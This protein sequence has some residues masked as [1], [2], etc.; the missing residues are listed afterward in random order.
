MRDEPNDLTALSFMG[1][2][3]LASGD[4][5]KAFS[6]FEKA[7]K[8]A[9]N[10]YQVHAD[11]AY[12]A[13]R[14]KRREKAAQHF[15]IA[16]KLN[17]DFYQAWVN[18]SKLYFEMERFTDARN[19]LD[20]S[21]ACDPMEAD[22][23]DIHRAMQEKAHGK[24]EKIARSMLD[25]VPG[26][27]RAAYVLAHLAGTVGAY[28]QATKILKNT[29]DL[30]PANYWTRQSLI[31]YLEKIGAYIPA[32]IEA[33]ILTKL[34]P[35]SHSWLIL[36][37]TYEQTGQY[38]DAL[39][40]LD[41]AA[42]LIAETPELQAT[43]D[44]TRGHLLKIHGRYGE[45]EQA[46]RACIANSP[47]NGAG[48]WGLAD[49]ENF[50]FSEDDQ[51]SML[52]LADDY[53][54]DQDQRCLAAFALAKAYEQDHDY[55]MAFH[56]FQKA[57]SLR[58]DIFFDPNKNQEFCDLLCATFTPDML[59][60]QAT[61]EPEGP[62]PI[63][64]V[65]LPRA[66]STLLEQI[67]ATHS[68]IESTTA[69]TTLP[70][71]ERRITIKGNEFGARYP[72]SLEYFSAADLS[73]FG[74]SYLDETAVY[75]SG[76]PYFIDRLPPNFERIGLIHKILPQA[77]IIDVRR[78]PL[79][80]GLSAYTQHFVAGHD[81]S[82]NMDHIGAYYNGY[83]Q[84]MDHWD[85]VISDKVI[86]VHYEQLINNPADTI[87]N[88]FEY[89]GIPFEEECLNFHTNHR[90]VGTASLEQ[91]P[92]PLNKKRIGRWHNYADNLTPLM[93]ALGDTTLARFDDI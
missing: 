68:K 32:I 31:Q 90:A 70:S 10:S 14:A 52:M 89:I 88:L 2:A 85:E 5:H 21:E 87:Q 6:Y 59:Q 77:I 79:D 38:E 4:Q 78:H 19:S 16:T 26:H 72:M 81:Y 39:N 60:A 80:C 69:F 66:G 49:F 33:K 92:G 82:Y 22:Y 1:S 73:R 61:P 17:P 44:Q 50:Q 8:I 74:Q 62:T 24:A 47:G 41:K 58:T 29:L 91:V 63:F 30:Y 23:L 36:S 84:I 57:N 83:L 71:L 64:I 40:A 48:W 34:R 25:K 54:A 75:R 93:D 12:A 37:Q 18:L 65:G 11:L 76:K 86:L 45:S 42:E 53:S 67:L 15:E 13:M 20:Q 51:T 43:I 27:P 56:W 28:E 3:C 9:P 7:I 35:D 46:Y 55:E